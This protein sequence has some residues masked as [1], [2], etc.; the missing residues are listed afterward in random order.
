MIL[1][2]G[3]INFIAA[4]ECCKNVTG[5]LIRTSF[6]LCQNLDICN[7]TDKPTIKIRVCGI[8]SSLMIRTTL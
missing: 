2:F 4:L 5:H 6:G 1:R 8:A 3:A 7:M